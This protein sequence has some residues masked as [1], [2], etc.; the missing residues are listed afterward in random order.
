MGVAFFV[1]LQN[2]LQHSSTVSQPVSGARVGDAWE[3][4]LKYSCESAYLG[5]LP[6]ALDLLHTAKIL[7]SLSLH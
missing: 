5:G 3:T 1:S 4:Y 2:F 7:L 6:W